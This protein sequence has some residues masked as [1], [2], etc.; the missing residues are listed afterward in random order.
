[1]ISLRCPNEN[2]GDLKCAGKCIH[3]TAVAHVIDCSYKDCP[4]HGVAVL[5]HDGQEIKTGILST[6]K[7]IRNDKQPDTV[8]ASLDW[9]KRLAM[10]DV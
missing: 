6:P 1:M 8:P 5:H 3:K 7:R 9:L 10:F 2:K 4:F